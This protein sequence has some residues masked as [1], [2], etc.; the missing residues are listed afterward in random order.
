MRPEGPLA[1]VIL[2]PACRCEA[3]RGLQE[4]L[5]L[6]EAHT[7]DLEERERAREFGAAVQPEEPTGVSLLLDERC[8][9]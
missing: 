7:F 2:G 3:H 1:F 8:P 4:L 5:G 9:A 6:V